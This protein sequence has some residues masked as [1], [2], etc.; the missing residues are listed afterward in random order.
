MQTTEQ[1]IITKS[2]EAFNA[3]VD[4]FNYPLNEH[5]PLIRKK[6]EEIISEAIEYGRYLEHKDD[7]DTR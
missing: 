7:K 1:Y 5:A 2:I 3:V 4:G 6:L